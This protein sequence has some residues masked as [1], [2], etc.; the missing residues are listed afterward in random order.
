[1]LSEAIRRADE[2]LAEMVEMSKNGRAS[3]EELRLGLAATKAMRCRLDLYQANAAAAL[4]ERERHSDGG[5]AELA[6]AAGM[7]RYD[8]AR[9]VKTAQRL[10]G[11]P[12]ARQAVEDGKVSFANAKTLADAADK[13]SACDVSA[14]PDLLAMAATHTPERFR[15]HMGRWVAQRQD[16][17]DA[18]TVYERQ[19]RLRSLNIWNGDDNMVHIY[20]QYDPVTGAR[21]HKQLLMRAEHLRREDLELPKHERRDYN[22][23]MADALDSLASSG[24][25]G[26]SGD[27]GAPTGIAIVQH[28]DKAGTQAFAEIVGGG[29]IP[30]SVLEEHF[31]GAEIVGVVFSSDGVP[32]WHGH[33]KQLATEAQKRALLAKYGGC[34]GC[35]DANPI[36][37]QAHHIKP[38]SQGGRTDID[39]LMPVCWHCHNKIHQHNWQVIPDGDLH[40]IEPPNHNPTRPWKPPKRT[41]H[42]PTRASKP[43]PAPKRDAPRATSKRGRHPPGPSDSTAHVDT[44]QITEASR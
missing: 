37:F 4:A 7:S 12:E 43:P 38:V 42:G 40:T 8:A 22:Q 10:Q 19:R 36:I 11:L 35:H 2:A 27:S 44:K 30:P 23:R 15:K 20:G 34:G 28:L 1:M 5:T 33:T 18:E 32:L 9:R 39:N 17:E 25:S 24:D 31:C 26:D 13:T 41:R 16:H 29:P 21:L 3:C 6:Q 14:D